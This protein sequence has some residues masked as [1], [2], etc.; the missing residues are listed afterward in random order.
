MGFIVKN[1]TLYGPLDLLCPHSCRGCGALGRALCDCCKNYILREHFNYCPFCKHEI[2]GHICTECALLPPFTMVGWKDSLIGDLVMEYKYHSTRAIGVELASIL[3]TLLPYYC[4]DTIIVPL[5]T[6]GKH[7]RERGFDH[8]FYVAKKL[9]KLRG[10]KVARILHRATNS[11]QVGAGAERRV[12]Q[13]FSTYELT[14]PR[15]SAEA[16]YVLLDDVWTTGAS[17]KA[18]TR[19]LREAGALK[20]SIAVLAVSR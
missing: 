8:M 2:P 13:A 11:V 10:Y 18:A 15:L 7:V 19:K 3:D 5:P 14:T 17:M 9:A 16:N 12:S 4:G 6:I 20:I 1:T